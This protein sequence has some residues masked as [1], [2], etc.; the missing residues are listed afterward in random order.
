MT[1]TGPIQAPQNVPYFK[2]PTLVRHSDAVRFL[3]GDEDS[4]F[5]PDVV[6]GRGD[7]IAALIYRLA[8]GNMFGSSK[9]WRPLYDQDR[10]Y[11][12][13]QGTL[14]IQ[15]PESGDVAVAHAGEAV[16]WRGLRFHYGYNVSDEELLVLDWYAP[17]ERAATVTEIETSLKKRDVS[18]HVEGRTDLLCRWPTNALRDLEH[19][20]SE[21]RMVT[22]RTDTALHFIHGRK[23]PVLMNIL[24]S[25]EALTGGDFNLLP[26]TM[27]EPEQHAGD[28][29]FYALEG[30][31]HVYLPDS[32]QWFELQPL[33]CLF[34]PE[35]TRHQYC[36]NGSKP[37]KGAFCVAP[38]YR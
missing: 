17:P 35:G 33:D 3:W 9:T 13:V 21:G 27:A 26:A 4:H 32:F 28:E 30:C 12:V 10:Y 24:A 14:A 8:P 23:T 22:L 38:R 20:L 11:Y 19:R 37:A 34:M 25:T 7:R 18:A 5:V 15:D 29:V 2:E 1:Q 16:Y 31:L 36:N 6:Y